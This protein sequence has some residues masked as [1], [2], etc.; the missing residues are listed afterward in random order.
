MTTR[1]DFV[2]TD[3][4]DRSRSQDDRIRAKHI[5]L[6]SLGW[7]SEDVALCNQIHTDILH[8]VVYP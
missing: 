8:H 1:D 7:E 4:L 6:D 2:N 5:G 3:L